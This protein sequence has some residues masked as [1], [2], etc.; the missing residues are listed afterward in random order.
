MA[1]LR[2]GRCYRKLKRPWTRQSKRKPKMGYVKGVP[3][4]RIRRFRTGKERDY[5]MILKLVSESNLQVRDNALE[6]ARVA[7]SNY[8]QKEIKDN[9]FLVLMKYPFHVLREHK[10]AA[11]AGA[12]RY[13]S[14]M[15]HAFGK[16]VGS[17]IQLRKDHVL[18]E[19]RL[20]QKHEK[21]GREA[22]RRAITKLPGPYRVDK[23]IAT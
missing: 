2:P 7:I 11:M 12:D 23:L 18:F 5:D 13:F 15:R 6:S 14:G 17:A 8:L 3:A 9:F 1:R 4:S 19:L 21:Y 16:P 22:L 20:Y 10:Q